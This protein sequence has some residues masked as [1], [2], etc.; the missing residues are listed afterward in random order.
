MK[1]FPVSCFFFLLSILT[2]QAQTYQPEKVNKKAVQQ[3]ELA[4]EKAEE[5]D[6]KASLLFLEKALAIDKKYADAYLSTAGIYGQLKNYDLAILNYE[7]ARSLDLHYF[8]EYNLS[9]SI[10]L[11]GKGNFGAALDA[12][13]LFLT[14]P[15]LNETSVKAAGYRKRCY[16][17]ALDYAKKHPVSA[18][19]FNPKNMGPEINTTDPEYFPSLTIDGKELIFTRRLNHYNE[20]FFE[21]ILQDGKW[22][23]A[24]GLSG[25]INTNLNEGA[26]HISQDGQMLVFTGCNFEDG[27]GSCDIY[28]SIK[29]NKG[30]SE[31]ANIGR[32]INTEFW[33]SQP[34]LSPDKRELYFASRR[35]DGYGGSDIYVSRREN[36]GQWGT[37]EN[38]GPEIN[39]PGDESCPFI[40]AGNNNLFFMSNGHPGYGGDDLF[41]SKRDQNGKWEQPLNLGYPVN[42]IENEGSL[43]I[44][45]D[46]VTA[47]YASDRSD[48]YGALDI[49]TFTLRPDLRPTKTLWVK[50][51]VYDAK[52]KAGLPSSVELT[53]LAN[54]RTI[55]R[56]QT[57][58]DGNYLI[59][60]PIGKEYAFNV[61]RKGYLFFSDHFSLMNPDTATSFERN[62]P[63][64]PIEANA[65]LVLRNIFFDVN[66]FELKTESRVELDKVVALLKENPAVVIQINGHTD[67][68]GTKED[69][70]ILSENRARAVVRYINEKGI[71][72]QRLKFKG[73]G[74]TQPVADNETETGRAQ[75]RRT[76]MQV[77]NL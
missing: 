38:L 70:R 24:K 10:N 1:I 8:A 52:T 6:L 71:T 41:T 20:D 25:N 68:T 17:F 62:I 3:Y 43:T 31:P 42:T 37:P 46:G 77:V 64:Q 72:A 66:K 7:K 63:L 67:N 14:I 32:A 76:E 16:T 33:D 26:Q 75:N 5:G 30:W 13:N 28:Y 57:D 34:C 56:L 54:N 73:W 2:L 15:T 69:N 47:Y 19:Q 9:Y 59:T 35:P 60:L 11:A 21:S 18:Y 58:E 50:G 55:S 53:D 27:F 29:T 12:L 48:S 45:A 36:N 22:S 4:M 39:T 65:S 74:D 61:N 44:A 51:Q 23:M 40:H 49:Y